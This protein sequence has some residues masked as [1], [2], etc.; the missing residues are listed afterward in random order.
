MPDAP[1]APARRAPRG[2]LRPWRR[3]LNHA[4][5]YVGASPLPHALALFSIAVG[6]A[7]ADAALGVFA[8]SEASAH[9][10]PILWAFSLG[11]FGLAGIALLDGFSRYREY[12][13]IR[14]MLERRGWDERVFLLVAGSRCQRDAALMAAMETGLGRRARALF[15]S[16]GYRWYHLFPDAV[17][18]NPLL[19]LHPRFLRTS[20]L[21]GKARSARDVRLSSASHPGPTSRR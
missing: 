14:C 3:A 4:V 7:L 6:L 12:R 19:F 9:P 21:P 2:G 10:S 1:A 16:L 5:R 17:M 8:A 15:R 18:R 20:F 13:R 11:W